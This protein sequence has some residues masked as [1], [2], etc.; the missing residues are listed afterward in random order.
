[1]QRKSSLDQRQQRAKQ[2]Q[3]R[4]SGPTPIDPRDFK[5]IAGGSPKGGW[6]TTTTSSTTTL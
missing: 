3:V 6:T 2:E 4:P 1:M 5:S